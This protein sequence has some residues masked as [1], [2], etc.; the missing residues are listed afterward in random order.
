MSTP[1]TP[2][3]FIFIIKPNINVKICKSILMGWNP[4]RKG[5]VMAIFTAPS[6][7]II[8]NKSPMKLPS[9]RP[10]NK[11]NIVKGIFCFNLCKI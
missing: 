6:G 5:V 10:N 2:K 11:I 3:R 8:P 1:I 7:S 9:I 4:I